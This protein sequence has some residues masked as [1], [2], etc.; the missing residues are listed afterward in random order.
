[1]KIVVFIICVIFAFTFSS[2]KTEKKETNKNSIENTIET[3]KS[4][5]LA[6]QCPMK[7][8]EEKTYEKVGKCPV[9]KMN[10]KRNK[11]VIHEKN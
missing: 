8:E 3:E 4:E 11:K 6:Y 10:L 2:C 9:C 5:K 7:C 1:M